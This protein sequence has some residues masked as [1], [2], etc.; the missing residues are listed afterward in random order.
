MIRTKDK[1]KVKHVNEREV[2]YVDNETN[3]VSSKT[4]NSKRVYS[5][6]KHY[7]SISHDIIE[8]LHLLKGSSL[9]VLMWGCK[10][11]PYNEMMISLSK[12]YIKKAVAETG[13]SVA[14]IRLALKHLCDAEMFVALGSGAYYINPVLAW[15]GKEN[16]RRETIPRFVEMLEEKSKEK[17]NQK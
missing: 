6:N 12:P 13:L 4:V 7:F 16:R 11:L 15:K 2:Y 1:I 10:Q 8:D 5:Y 14:A 17:E 3:E 9:K